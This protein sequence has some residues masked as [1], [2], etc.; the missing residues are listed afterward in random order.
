MRKFTRLALM[1]CVSTLGFAELAIAKDLGDGPWAKE[2]FQFRARAIGILADGD[3]MVNGTAL[4]TDVGDA[5]TPEFDVTYF[6]TEHLAA[7]LIAATAEHK[8]EAGVNDLGDTWILPPTLTLQYH[9]M[10]DEKFSPYI[11]AGINYSYFYGE[12]SG[13]GFNDLDVEGGFGLAA[14]AGF[15]YWLNDN[16]GLNF[17]VKYID[18]DVDVDV[19]LGTTPLAA[20]NVD[21]NPWVVGAGVSYRF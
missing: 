15:D 12:D 1:A 18:L 10:P 6:F 21:L 16:W 5:V 14:Q 11:G 7:E 20:D 8:V 13:R 17:D 9:F 19:N 2:R 3:G 4:K